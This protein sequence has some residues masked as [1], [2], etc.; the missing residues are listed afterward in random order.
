MKHWTVDLETTTDP[1]DCRV[2]AWAACSIEDPDITEIGIDLPGLIR[3]MALQKSAR[4]YFH[5]LKFDSEFLFYYLIKQGYRHILDRKEKAPRTFTTLISDKNMFYSTSIYFDV[6]GKKTIKADIFDSQK[7]IPLSVEK[8][9]AAFGLPLSKL[10]IDYHEYRAPGHQLTQHERDYVTNDVK[11]MALAL[12]QL[13]SQGMDKMT[14]GSNAL[15]NFKELMG[16]NRFEKNFPV[17][18]YDADIR[19][20]YRGGWVY[21]LPR[22]AGQ[23]IAGGLV[24]DVNSLYPWAMHSPNRLPFSEPIWF[25]GQYQ[26]DKYYPLYVQQL[27]CQFEIKPGKLPTIQLKNNPAFCSTEYL[28][29]SKKEFVTLTLTNLDLELFFEHYDVYNI[30]YHSGWKFRAQAGLFDDY[31]DHWNNEKVQA[32]LENNPGKRTISKLMLNSLYGKFAT[33][34]NV[35]SKAPYLD[36]ETDTI[37]YRLLPPETR[38]AVYIPVGAFITSI[39]RNKTIRA[40]QACHD[41]GLFIYSDTDSLHILGDAAP[42][43]LE[44]DETMLGCWK[45]ENRFTKARFLRAKC[46]METISKPEIQAVKEKVTVAGMPEQLHQLVTYDNFRIGQAFP[47]L[48]M[49]REGEKI[50]AKLRPL[51]V[52]GGIVLVDDVFTIRER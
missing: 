3:F 30:T 8:V 36:L 6:T 42:S 11:I 47:D 32:S 23:D 13:F 22:Y 2:W 20:A 35:Q 14:V 18:T 15:N 9:A 39:A 50:K 26:A 19:Q 17:P 49:M 34:P 24:L 52:P 25:D 40:A 5:N 10:E 16:R 44:I 43:A 31:I 48:T 1:A 29:D 12:G 33:S 41:Q 7:M 27:T 45:I 28:T 51:H 4:W 37:K 38:E 21:L 46:Y